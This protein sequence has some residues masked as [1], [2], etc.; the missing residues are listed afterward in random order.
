MSERIRKQS[1]MFLMRIDLETK[2]KARNLSDLYEISVAE[3]I[4]KLICAE[5]TRSLM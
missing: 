1:E 4:R 3:L 5:Y 2:E